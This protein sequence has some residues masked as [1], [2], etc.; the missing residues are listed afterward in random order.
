M[1]LRKVVPALVLCGAALAVGHVAAA[2]DGA[3]SE[4]QPTAADVDGPLPRL[5]EIGP[6]TDAPEGLSV[7]PAIVEVPLRPGRRSE[8]VHVVANATGSPITLRL[9]SIP[10]SVGRDGPKIIDGAAGPPD[11]GGPTR[12]VLPL[13]RLALDDGEGAELRSTGEV[14]PGR[15]LVVALR[16]TPLPPADA[17]DGEAAVAYVVLTDGGSP[18]GLQVTATEDGATGTLA[19]VGLATD[20]H[21]VVDVRVRVHSWLGVLHDRTTADLL[22]GPD[23]PRV[24]EVARPAGSPPGRLRLE[25]VV[26]DRS[27]VEART[28]L[29]ATAGAAGWLVVLAVA[30]VL[31][32]AAAVVVAG[33]RLRSAARRPSTTPTEPPPVE[34]RDP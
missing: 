7:S 16:A 4:D 9:E 15:S 8:V 2:Q 10:A 22:V 27:G 14:A 28:S 21:A 34:E 24:L 12:L 17:E 31:T 20:R 19:V 29:T 25:V 1:S 30:F 18:S 26:V 23:E 32:A 33:R 5:G 3:G 13:D 6:V 11:D